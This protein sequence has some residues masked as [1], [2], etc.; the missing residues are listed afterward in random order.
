VLR[1][2]ADGR[3][4]LLVSHSFGSPLPG[5]IHVPLPGPGWRV[6]ARYPSGTLPALQDGALTLDLS[7]EWKG[8]AFYLERAGS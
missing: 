7:A 8:S 5:E 6:T 2:A 4:A 1:T 3:S